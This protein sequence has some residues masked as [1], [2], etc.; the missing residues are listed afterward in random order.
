MCGAELHPGDEFCDMCGSRVES[1]PRLELS[2][3]EPPRQGPR[4]DVGD[5]PSCPVC[6]TRKSGRFCEEDGYD[7]DTGRQAERP[8]AFTQPVAKPQD[9]TAPSGPLPPAKARTWTAVI[10]ADREYF[11]A[12]RAQGGPDA[13]AI[14]FPPY[15]PDRLVSLAGQ[16]VQ[17]GRRSAS[18]GIEPEIDLSVP[19]EDPGVSR[20]HAVLLA[21]PDG[22]WSLVDPGSANGTTLN[23]EL[24]PVPVNVPVPLKDGDR[25][26]VGA[27]TTLTLRSPE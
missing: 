3:E 27:W 21:Q 19:P 15:C 7:F 14:A 16:R 26:H 22:S 2:R 12:V 25:V 4:P 18:R 20:L 13:A 9:G 1:A 10:A 11:E 24:D 6:G 23:D 17:I 8:Q 5:V